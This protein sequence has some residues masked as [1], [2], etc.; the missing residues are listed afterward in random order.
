MAMSVEDRRTG[1]DGLQESQRNG[2]MLATDLA[3]PYNPLVFQ[4]IAGGPRNHP[5]ARPEWAWFESLI[6]ER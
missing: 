4:V 6:E 2:N 3:I 5:H 1:E